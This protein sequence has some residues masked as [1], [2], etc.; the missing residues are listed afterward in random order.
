M[1][2]VN[3]NASVVAIKEETTEG[4]AVAPAAAGDYVASQDDFSMEAAFE[5]LENAEL[6]STIG[7][8][9]NS[10]GSENPSAQFSHYLRH[11]GTEGTA[12][13]YKL[14]LKALFGNEDVEGAEYNTVSS[15]T[16]SVIKVDSAEGA[17]YRQG[18]ALLIKDAT[19][20]Y[21]IRP[22]DS[23][24]TDDL[25]IAFP[26]GTAPG[27]GVD[28]GQAIT[29]Y[30]ANSGHPALSLWHYLGNQGAI[31]MMSGARVTS[32]TFNMEAGG[33][34]NAS[35]NLEGL[36]YFFN[37]I[38]IASADT[39]I[40]FTDDQGTVAAQITAGWYKDPHEL[41]AAIQTAMDNATSETITCTYSDTTGKFTIATSTSSVLSLLWNSGS[42]AA[43]T[44]GDKIGF[45]TAADDTSATTYTGDDAI[46]LSAPQTPTYDSADPLV[47]KANELIIGDGTETTC[48]Q[49]QSVTV[50]FTNSRKVKESICATSGRSG[51][52]ISA[53]D[54]T[55]SVVAYLDQYDVD[56][57]K[58]YRANTE[59]RFMYNAG[60]KSGGNWVE[61]TC[62]CLYSPQGTIS[63]F[64][65]S[66]DEGLT[67][68]NFEFK[69][70]VA[71]NG[72]AEL[73]LSFV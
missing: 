19:N 16:T 60:T 53:R 39:Y 42:N 56:K 26:V 37:P 55:I 43:N 1:T 2:T 8:S 5:Q 24:S 61:G 32:A 72:D 64:S 31:Q 67:A 30:M 59:T 34:I 23:I 48:L 28:L 69:P 7:A 70:F 50:N 54:I 68:V 3:F 63:S 45:S 29:Y 17:N 25:T 33:Y 73:M 18:Q 10:L 4:T 12:P 20:G 65:L 58:R 14:L 6:S 38:N 62:Y 9:K 15:S 47:A 49:A 35:Y 13:N 11:S 51:S 21:S 41:A 52:I 27:T 57:F 66:N 44:V 40:D 36:E 71:S 22:V 46:D